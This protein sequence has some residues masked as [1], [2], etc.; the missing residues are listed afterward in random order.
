LLG[1]THLK[2]LIRIEVQW[3]WQA[4]AG[5]LAGRLIL[6]PRKKSR[7][8]PQRWFWATQI[9]G[10]LVLTGEPSDLPLA[11][12]SCWGIGARAVCRSRSPCR[13]QGMGPKAGIQ[14]LVLQ[15]ALCEKWCISYVRWLDGCINAAEL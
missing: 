1:V 8:R 7:F 10:A 6:K 2:V 11:S 5:S 13:G 15:A 3:L 14:G 12:C 4:Q 9:R